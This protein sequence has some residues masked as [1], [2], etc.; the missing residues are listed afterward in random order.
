MSRLRR[1]L[2]LVLLTVTVAATAAAEPVAEARRML[3]RL[4]AQAPVEAFAAAGREF[5]RLVDAA[6][7][8]AAD[9]ATVQSLRGIAGELQ[10]RTRAR[11]RAMEAATGEV[12]AELERLYRSGEWDTLSFA[13][14][15]FPYWQAWLDLT[16]AQQ[17]DAPAR[18][19][20]ALYQAE[21][22]FRA[23]SVQIVH[24]GLVYG[25]WLGLTYVA[26]A[27]GRDTWA[28]EMLERLDQA[29]ARSPDNPLREVVQLELR[30]LKAQ[31][32]EVSRTAMTAAEVASLD[33]A[34]A[35][36]L[37]M[38]AFALLEQHRRDEVGGKDA[39]V[40]LKQVL[41]SRHVDAPLIARILDYREEII[42]YDIGPLGFLVSAEDALINEHFYT[43][44]EKYKA[45]F[46][47]VPPNFDID[48]NRFRYRH[49]VAALRGELYNDALALVESLLGRPDLD[50]EVR[51]AATR[52]AWMASAARYQRTGT[53]A[54]RRRLLRA[55]Q[56]FIERSPGDASADDARLMIARVSDSAAVV[57]SAIGG[58]RGAGERR[59]EIAEA[60]FSV[61]ARQFAAALRGRDEQAAMAL[62]RQGS[63]LAA[64]MMDDKSVPLQTR[65][66]IVQ[67]RAMLG[68]RP[69]EQ[70]AAIE[71]MSARD[72]IGQ[73]VREMLLWSQLRLL[74]MPGREAGLRAAFAELGRRELQPWQAEQAYAALQS[75]PAGE[76]R[77]ALSGEL[78]PALE[79]TPAIARRLALQR[80]E[81]A[82]ERGEDPAAAYSRARAFVE[83]NPRSGD[84]WR[85]LALAA[86]QAGETFEAERAW[87]VVTENLRPDNP[88]WT[89]GMLRRLALRAGSTRPD[90]A[91]AILVLLQPRRDSL[92]A[93]QR[94]RLDAHAAQ[95]ACG[96]S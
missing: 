4:D 7:A 30:L 77:E 74:S 69:E 3:A 87:R 93:A 32:G 6:R 36:L 78:M 76:L 86:E 51:T 23:A 95:L 40:R 38:E 52:L 90:A 9:L 20:A 83:A 14:A 50:A 28:R 27:Q 2:W 29:L 62:A 8:D 64:G 96:E 56:A 45:F 65:A 57:D 21:R 82:V 39:A 31:A 59:A 71:W 47:R 55:A 85:I 92:S 25:G 22:G 24:P 1:C 43:A 41:A 33:A 79:R 91:C 35:R 94:E 58:I 49:A 18:R 34:E 66:I 89:T 75:L 46:A 61:V 60:R 11:L 5:G 44:D 67:M 53:D 54:D 84:A 68:E 80:L 37:S 12:E 88:L 10:A 15:A 26:R 16:A 42:G 48:L 72:D 63:R 70:L 73:P 13:I 81:Q 17:L 19:D